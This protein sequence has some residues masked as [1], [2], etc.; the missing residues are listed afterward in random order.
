MEHERTEFARIWAFLCK[1]WNR[2]IDESE[3]GAYWKYLRKR[4]TSDEIAAAARSLWATREFFPRPVDFLAAVRV[5]I[6]D[7]IREAVRLR[8]LGEPWTKAIDVGSDA[9]ECLKA[10]GGLEA[11][12]RMVDL[13][14]DMLRREVELALDRMAMRDAAGFESLLQFSR[15]D[16]RRL[17]S[18]PEP[19]PGH[20]LKSVPIAKAI[21]PA[22]AGSGK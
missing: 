21:E 19:M 10:I 1:R 6:L 14:P 8:S 7:D 18:G 11:A 4:L 5:T 22:A 20:D 15:D 2:E 13:R 16:T 9:H 17:P 3:L 12:T